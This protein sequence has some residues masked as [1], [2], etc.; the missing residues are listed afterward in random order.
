[1]S[2]QEEAGTRMEQLLFEIATYLRASAASA[3]KGKASQVID[4]H[5]K[6]ITYKNL[7]GHTTQ[8]KIAKMLDVTSMAVSYYV[9]EFVEAGLAMPPSKFYPSHKA[10]F[11]LEELG[12]DIKQLKKQ[13]LAK[14]KKKIVTPQE[15]L[16][17]E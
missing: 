8:A 3:L 17:E 5:R 12:I 9:Q 4:T 1:M 7:D 13:E 14:T 2:E 6:A 11:T 15:A 16:E 10:L